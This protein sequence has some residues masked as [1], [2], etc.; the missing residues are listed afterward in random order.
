M[1]LSAG[2]SF[3]RAEDFFCSLKVRNGGLGISKLQFLIK[4]I[5]ILFSA[6]KYFKFLVIKTLDPDPHS[7][8]KCWILIRIR[9]ETNADPKH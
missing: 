7:N 5:Q 4:K 6:V 8:V 9:L 3:V 1:F 2:Y